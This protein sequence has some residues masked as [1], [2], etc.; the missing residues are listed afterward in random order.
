[1]AVDREFVYIEWRTFSFSCLFSSPPLSLIVASRDH[2]TEV[3][4]QVNKVHQ[5][6]MNTAKHTS[7]CSSRLDH[8][9]GRQQLE[10]MAS[11]HSLS[12]PLSL[13]SFLPA[14]AGIEKGID[15]Y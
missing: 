13:F 6:A 1:M 15:L 7:V 11:W 8:M 9:E 12:L 4:Q 2:I 5:E 10:F 14:A 3:S